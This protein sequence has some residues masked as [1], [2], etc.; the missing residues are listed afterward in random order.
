[1]NRNGWI[2]HRRP[3]RSRDERQFRRDF[4][5]RHTEVLLEDV[6]QSDSKTIE[7]ATD[8]FGLA[9]PTSPP[10]SCGC[11]RSWGPVAPGAVLGVAGEMH[12]LGLLLSLKA[13]DKLLQLIGEMDQRAGDPARPARRLHPATAL[14]GV[15][16][17]RSLYLREAGRAETVTR[18]A[19]PV[20]R[21]RPV[22]DV[23][24]GHR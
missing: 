17:D 16:D 6:R 20:K 23:L 14:A 2:D 3:E 4:G 15:T 1:M 7:D 19:G 10:V 22:L 5:G 8:R 24:V 12:K 13:L 21:L 18:V 9:G 11:R